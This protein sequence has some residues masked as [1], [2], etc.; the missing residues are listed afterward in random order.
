MSSSK[1][2]RWSGL[3]ALAGGLLF[4]I[5]SVAEFIAGQDR[6]PSEAAATSAWPIIEGGYV[7]TVVL[8]GLGLVGLYARQAQRAGWLGLIA[9]LVTFT[10]VLLTAGSA[11]SQAFL[12]PWLARTAP[13]LLDSGSADSMFFAFWIS[14]IVFSLGWFL[15]GLA[16]LRAGVL[17]RGASILFMIGAPLPIILGGFLN[18]PFGGEVVFAA[19]LAW[20]GYEL[21]SGAG[22]ASEPASVAEAAA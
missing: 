9:F 7:V 19:A 3:A 11:W 10:G 15:F 22:A 4:I 2:I 1:L 12:G 20:A 18:V 13:E 14:Y 21:W 6:L 17:S 16:S 5:F 8:I